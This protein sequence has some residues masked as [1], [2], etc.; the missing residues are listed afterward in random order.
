MNNVKFWW[1]ISSIYDEMRL[2]T[3]CFQELS[4]EIANRIGI[5]R[6]LFLYG[7]AIEKSTNCDFR[8]LLQPYFSRWIDLF[9]IILV[10][11]YPK[12]NQCIFSPQTNCSIPNSYSY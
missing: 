2:S 7:E 5:F 1:M 6:Q 10:R 4:I 12:P 9:I 3:P 8:R 11:A